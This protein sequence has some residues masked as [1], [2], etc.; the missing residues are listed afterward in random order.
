MFICIKKLNFISNFFWDIVK[1]LQ[2][3]YIGNFENASPS[4][5]KII[6][7]SCSKLSCL[8]LSKKGNFITH[9]FFKILQRRM[10][11]WIIWAC[12]ATS[13]WYDITNLKK[14]LKFIYKRDIKFILHVFFENCRVV[15]LV[16]LGMPGY[17]H[18]KQ[19]Y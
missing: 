5:L 10:L 8:S 1:T 4:P 6:A 15:I 11:F 9:F 12:I 19:Y 16:T 18:P 13:T 7:S 3:C 2:T 14:P 17:T